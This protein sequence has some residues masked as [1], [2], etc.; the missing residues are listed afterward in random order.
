M[1]IIDMGDRFAK[2]LV[3]SA[4]SSVIYAGLNLFSYYVL[5]FTD[6]RYYNVAAVMI[7]G[8]KALTTGESIFAQMV[9]I[10]FATGIGIVFCYLMA[11]FNSKNYVFKGI[12]W[13][14]A[15]WFVIVSLMTITRLNN[16]L[17]IGLNSAISNLITSCIWGLFIAVVLRWLD[18]GETKAAVNHKSRKSFILKNV[19][20]VPQPALKR[21]G[22]D[23]R[24]KKPI[25]AKE[26][27]YRKK[28]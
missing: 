17:P 26:F 24:F 8:H 13:G 3:A 15:N 23:N 2:G 7:F 21:I 19:K 16:L 14:A 27:H 10:G 5:H 12:F 18:A 25:R 22:S 4:I 20:L 9:Q 1:K 6:Q 28:R 11:K